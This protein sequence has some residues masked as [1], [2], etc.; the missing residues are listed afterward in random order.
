VVEEVQK[1]QKNLGPDTVR[2]AWVK[3]HVGTQGDEK[4]EQMAKSRAELGDEEE[5]KE[6]VIMQGDLRQEWKRRRAEER[7]V[8][9]TGMGQTVGRS[10]GM[11]A[12]AG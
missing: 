11:M 5:G 1:R 6:K 12:R 4:A 3:A 10:R 8:K 7:K 2:F 9:G